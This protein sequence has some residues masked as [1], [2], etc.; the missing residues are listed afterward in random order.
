MAYYG[1]PAGGDAYFTEKLFYQPWDEATED[2]RIRALA[3]A[4]QLIDR[5]RFSGSKTDADQELEFPRNDEVA[6]P[7]NVEKAAYEIALALLDG[8]D[9][10]LEHQNLA[11]SSDGYSSARATYNRTTA[12]EHF[13]AG[14]P[15]RRA[16]LF[17]RPYLADVRSVK[18]RKV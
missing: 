9:P 14:I 16:W 5:L 8:V 7:D 10:D 12:P 3:E 13:T 4:A 2:Q 17:L 18:L 1:T 11:I 6:V 15:S